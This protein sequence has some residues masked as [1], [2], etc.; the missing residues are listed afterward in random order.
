LMSLPASGYATPHSTTSSTSLPSATSKAPS[1]SKPINVFSNDGSFLERF[2]RS[3]QKQFADRFVRRLVQSPS[4]S[5]SHSSHTQ[6]TRGKHPPP[7]DSSSAVTS[8]DL[9]PNPA[10][11]PKLDDPPQSKYQQKLRDHA[12]HILKD[13]GTGV[14]PLVK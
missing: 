14:R 8:T 3:K 13:T 4:I 1:K 2:Q 10:K 11:K 12:G 6:K 7:P 5:I 9:D